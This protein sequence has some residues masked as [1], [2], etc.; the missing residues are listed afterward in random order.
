M[1]YKVRKRVIWTGDGWKS[2]VRGLCRL[3]KYHWTDTSKDPLLRSEQRQDR[4]E[5]YFN[6]GSKCRYNNR[7][8]LAA[9]MNDKKLQGSKAKRNHYPDERWTWTQ[10]VTVKI[11]KK[12]SVSGSI[13]KVNYPKISWWFYIQTCKQISKETGVTKSKHWRQLQCLGPMKHR[14]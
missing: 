4:S 13:L 10:M 2:L 8:I 7:I 6:A 5:L 11:M 3:C 9:I 1:S 14:M 12:M